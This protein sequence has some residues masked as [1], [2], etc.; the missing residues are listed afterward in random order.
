[1]DFQGIHLSYRRGNSQLVVDKMQNMTSSM[2][3]LVSKVGI[4]HKIMLEYR[5][6]EEI[7]NE[8]ISGSFRFRNKPSLTSLVING[9]GMTRKD[10]FSPSSKKVN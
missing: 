1:M 10:R 7:E 9:F 3:G 4:S 2:F 5:N 6:Q 8:L